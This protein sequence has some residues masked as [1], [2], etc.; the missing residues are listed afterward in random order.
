[1]KNNDLDNLKGLGILFSMGATL[2]SGVII[3]YF[4]GR[5]LD[6]LFGTK[7]WLT[8][9]MLFVGMGAGFKGVYESMFPDREGDK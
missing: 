3:G 1:M 7:P 6:N 9:I 4:L 5:W 2:A 8:F